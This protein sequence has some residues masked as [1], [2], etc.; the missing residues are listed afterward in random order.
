MK[1]ADALVFSFSVGFGLF[2]GYSVFSMRVHVSQ[3]KPEKL[4]HQVVAP[5][6]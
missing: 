2:W 6:Y 3:Q 4:P 5:R 1:K